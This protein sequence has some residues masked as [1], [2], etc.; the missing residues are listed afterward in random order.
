MRLKFI[1]RRRTELLRRHHSSLGTTAS[2][3]Q[4]HLRFCLSSSS[5]YVTSYTMMDTKRPIIVY[6]SED[7]EILRRRRR[8]LPIWSFLFV[9][10]ISSIMILDS[11]FRSLIPSRHRSSLKALTIEQRATKILKENP[12][13]GLNSPC[14]PNLIVMF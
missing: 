6:T 7:D 3:L 4:E 8:R 13:I 14:K 10:L 11:Q 12:L 2:C 1:Q 9:V 5:C